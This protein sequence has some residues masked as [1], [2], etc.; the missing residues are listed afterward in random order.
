[1]VAV[2]ILM[3]IIQIRNGQGF[4]RVRFYYYNVLIKLSS[5]WLTFADYQGAAR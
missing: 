1:M 2:E 3:G 4:P 5:V